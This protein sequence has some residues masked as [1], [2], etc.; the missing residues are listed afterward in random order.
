MTDM[1]AGKRMLALRNSKGMRMRE[2]LEITRIIAKRRRNPA[3]QVALSRLSEIEAQ[4]RIPK[5]HHLYSLAFA[6]N[7]SLKKLLSFYGLD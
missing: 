7:V 1:K 6:Y 2:V 4:G 5:L 3:F